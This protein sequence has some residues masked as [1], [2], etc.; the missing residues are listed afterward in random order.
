ML[1]KLHVCVIINRLLEV[2]GED[3]SNS[4]HKDILKVLER[5]LNDGTVQIV[6]CRDNLE[7]E[8]ARD[9]DSG[10][11]IEQLKEECSR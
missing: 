11:D 5:Q 9:G 2:N 8:E 6:V 7:G 1:V 10:G 4:N 3:V